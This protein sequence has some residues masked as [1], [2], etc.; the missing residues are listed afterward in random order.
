VGAEGIKYI[1]RLP[2]LK[3]LTLGIYTYLITDQ[4]RIS[5]EMMLHLAKISTL[6]TLKL[7]AEKVKSCLNGHYIHKLT[8]VSTLEILFISH[9]TEHIKW[10]INT[11]LPHT[12]IDEGW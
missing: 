10:L 4:N 3:I 7:K 6:Q 2:N 12:N 11:R 5:D 8:N 1:S 9:L